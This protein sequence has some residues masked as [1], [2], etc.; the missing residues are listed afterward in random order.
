MLQQ[1]KS[2]PCRFISKSSNGVIFETAPILKSKKA[3][4]ALHFPTNLHNGR[5]Q[6]LGNSAPV[7]DLLFRTVCSILYL[8]NLEMQINKNFGRFLE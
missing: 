2:L 7:F 6:F 1:G 8:Q 5:T 4:S 3:E